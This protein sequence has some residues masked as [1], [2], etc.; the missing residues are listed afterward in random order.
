MQNAY[1]RAT[2][3]RLAQLRPTLAPHVGHQI[4]IN[5]Y[6]TIV[7]SLDSRSDADLGCRYLGFAVW[8]KCCGVSL[9]EDWNF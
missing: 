1:L 3:E 4:S 8:C 6:D 5:G 7:P 9:S 2:D